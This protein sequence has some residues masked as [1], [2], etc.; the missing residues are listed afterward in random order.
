MGASKSRNHT[1]GYPKPKQMSWYWACCCC[2][3]EIP[4]L[5]MAFVIFMSATVDVMILALCS[6]RTKCSCVCFY[7]CPAIFKKK[8]RPV[9]KII[10]LHVKTK[11]TP[12]DPTRV[13]WKYQ[14]DYMSPSR[15]AAK[16]LNNAD[17]TKKMPVNLQYKTDE[18]YDDFFATYQQQFSLVSAPKSPK[19]N[20]SSSLPP[21][22]KKAQR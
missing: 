6:W 16:V 8:R 1:A 13:C 9:M 21:L 5:L 7:C 18:E 14:P 17:F 2:C 12:C 22:K 15:K 4:A 10:P 20:H 11:T 3:C 19:K